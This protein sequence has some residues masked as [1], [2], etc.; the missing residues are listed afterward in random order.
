VARPERWTALARVAR[1][2]SAGARRALVACKAWHGSGA[3]AVRA[4]GDAREPN[5]GAGAGTQRNG[6][7]VSARKWR[8]QER[9]GTGVDAARA[10]GVT[11]TR[12]WH[13]SQAALERFADGAGADASDAERVARACAR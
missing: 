12:E 11:L 9:A 1:A 10:R 3:K 4:S 8:E 13:A 2:S 7:S 5:L 6:S